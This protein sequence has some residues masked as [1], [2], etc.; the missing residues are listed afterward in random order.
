MR[1]SRN[2]GRKP[3]EI[4]TPANNL[5]RLLRLLSSAPCKE[6]KL[7]H[8]SLAAFAAELAV[9]QAHRSHSLPWQDV[10]VYCG[11]QGVDKCAQALFCTASPYSLEPGM[12]EWPSLGKY[13]RLPENAGSELYPKEARQHSGEK[14]ISSWVKLPGLYTCREA[15]ISTLEKFTWEHSLTS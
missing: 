1:Y 4:H 8:S 9:N 12:D 7:C 13:Y 10:N 5:G 2:S 14:L 15:E 11:L 3:C 6:L